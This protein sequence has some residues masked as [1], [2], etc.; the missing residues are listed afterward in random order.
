M[1]GQAAAQ[2]FFPE[3]AVLVHRGERNPFPHGSAA[4]SGVADIRHHDPRL[5][6][7]ALEQGCSRSDRPRPADNRVVRID[8]ERR[9]EGVHGAAQP[10]VETGL[11][12]E[13]L[14]IGAV[15]EEPQGEAF[16]RPAV[17]LLHRTEQRTVAIRFHDLE[18]PLFVKRPDG[19]KTLGQNFA[20]A[21][22]RSE[23]MIFG[24]QPKC[25]PD[26]RGFLADR[27]VRRP[28][29]IIRDSLV[30]ALGLDLVEDRL[31]FANPAHVDPDVQEVFGRV[32]RELFLHRLSVGIHL[33]VHEANG[34]GGKDLFRFDDD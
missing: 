24:R 25:H 32:L 9:E 3:I 30:C 29:V 10:T 12:R 22:M 1:I 23:D 8:P 5:A 6:V 7:H 33:N 14:A 18:Q 34:V 15:N 27:K 21:S 17:S 13:N 16:H 2:G 20:V 19:R 28:G 26:R 31:E 11:A 4:E